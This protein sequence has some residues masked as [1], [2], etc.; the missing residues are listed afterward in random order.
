MSK[1]IF[2]KDL[3]NL[4]Y[5]T[6]GLKCGL[7]IHQQLDTGKLFCNCLCIIVPNNTLDKSIDRTLRF[8]LS[9]TGEVDKAALAESRIQ[10]VNT[11]RYN[12]KVACLVDLDEEPPGPPNQKA[13]DTAVRIGQMLNL[14]FFDKVQFMR[15]LI[16]DGSI[17]SGFQRTAML[18]F[19]GCLDTEFGKV[20]IDGINLEEDA[21]R[22]I[23]RGEGKSIFSLD[24]Q[25]IPLVEV[26]TGPQVHTPE[27]GYELAKQLG[28]ILRSFDETRR[29][30]G[31]IRQDLNVSIPEGQRVEIKGAQNL[32]LIPD[33]IKAE[34]RRQKIMASLIEEGKARNITSKSVLLSEVVDV[35][36]VF[37]K[38]ESEVIKKNLENKGSV[39]AGIK[40]ENCKGLLGHEIQENFRFATEI[41]ERNKRYFP[42]IKGLF[43]SDEMPNYGISEQ[44]VELVKGKL[45]MT[46]ND[47]FILLANKKTVVEDSFEF[48]KEQISMLLSESQTEVRQVDPKGTTTKFLRPMPGSAR[49]YPE[50]DV[51]TIELVDSYLD[52][53]KSKIP[54][55]YDTKI[56]RVSK[57]LELDKTKTEDMLSQFTE[58]EATNLIKESGKS[59]SALYSILFDLPKDIRKRENLEPVDFRIDLLEQLVSEIN[60]NNLNQKTIRDIFISLYKDNLNS[61]A[62]LSTYIKEK[63]LVAD[64]INDE[65]LEA[66][67]KEIV[68]NNK[69]APFGALM[70][71]AMKEFN[72]AVDGKKLSQLLKKLS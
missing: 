13:L 17:T 21:S 37:E 22:I 52:S 69:G 45:N 50:T 68:D 31:T 64:E 28:T 38:T 49:M 59:A 34:V 1:L 26:T 12:D 18:G 27:Q 67:I 24:R 40:L 15:K 48:I 62:S 33:I 43:H 46:E 6:V 58:K 44:E 42:S 19:G 36:D 29:G 65:V 14:K 56:E 47:A 10:K 20:S 57:A 54:E 60:Q 32:K 71:L 39:V 30:L 51:K 72:G 55:L 35:T 23:E 66:K 61:V 2:L 53:L 9:E 41:S 11:Y 7:E 5:S 63:N 4:D 16:I 70:G 25:G 8:S 3:E